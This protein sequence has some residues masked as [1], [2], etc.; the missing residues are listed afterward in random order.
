MRLSKVADDWRRGPFERHSRALNWGNEEA[1][2]PGR[3]RTRDPLLRR[4]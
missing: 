4:H 2:A 1:G 3:I